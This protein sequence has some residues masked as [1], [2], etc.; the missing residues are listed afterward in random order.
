MIGYSP[1]TQ[2]MEVVFQRGAV[3]RYTGVPPLVFASFVL[4]ASKGR[5]FNSNVKNRYAFHR[6]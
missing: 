3:Y 5:F 2:S 6:V 1:L 4:A